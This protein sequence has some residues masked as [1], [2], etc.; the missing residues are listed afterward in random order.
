MHY[1][2]WCER[3]R[4]QTADDLRDRHKHMHAYKDRDTWH[5]A[6][7]LVNPSIHHFESQLLTLNPTYI[8]C[9]ISSELGSVSGSLLFLPDWVEIHVCRFLA[10]SY[11]LETIV[12]CVMFSSWS[13][14]SRFNYASLS[15]T[16]GNY[17][18]TTLI[19]CVRHE[20]TCFMRYL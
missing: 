4:R 9:L 5:S 20:L 2:H 14:L 11:K 6:R 13:S 17:L 12:T 1:S 15:S 7:L 3:K 19:R 16:V 18:K 10:V 8:M